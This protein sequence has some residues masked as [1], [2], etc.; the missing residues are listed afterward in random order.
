V[1]ITYDDVVAHIGLTT[2]VTTKP[3]A[4]FEKRLG[5]RLT[6]ERERSLRHELDKRR[7]VK[8]ESKV[9]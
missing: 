7:E 9:A 5:T 4:F 6:M 2:N 8:D 3:R 1:L